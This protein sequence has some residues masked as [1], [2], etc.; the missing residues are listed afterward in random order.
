M[1]TTPES[2]YPS[3]EF[4]FFEAR[5]RLDPE[6][7]TSGP[8]GSRIKDQ[9]KDQ[10]SKIGSRV[11]DQGSDQGSMIKDKDHGSKIRIKDL[12]RPRMSILEEIRT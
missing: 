6:A 10:G 12:V 11:K 8:R 9:I 4:V 7:S 2:I 3:Y 1:V 5:G